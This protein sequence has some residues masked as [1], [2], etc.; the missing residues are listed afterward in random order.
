MLKCKNRSGYQ[1]GNLL[2]IV[3]GLKGSSQS[4]FGFSKAYIA[5]NQT[6]HRTFA[7]HIC[8]DIGSGS[9]LIGRVLKHKGSLQ[10]KLHGS[11]WIVSKTCF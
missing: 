7:F 2:A 8:F 1:N 5:T 11:I 10:F 9:D 6:V 4:N 3:N